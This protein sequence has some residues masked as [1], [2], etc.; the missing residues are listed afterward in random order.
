MFI[1]AFLIL[2]CLTGYIAASHKLLKLPIQFSPFFS[3]STISLTLYLC[4]LTG[5]LQHGT[6]IV[7]IFGFLLAGLLSVYS[8]STK[9]L[10]FQQ[11][12]KN[13]LLILFSLSAI[14]LFYAWK[15]KFSVIDDY[16]YWGI[17]GKYIHISNQLPDTSTSIMPRHLG[18]TPGT[19]LF[20]YLFFRVAG[21]YS[22]ELSY[23]AQNTILS[24]ILFVFVRP[25]KL[26]ESAFI[27]CITIILITLQFGSTIVSRNIVM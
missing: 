21:N 5:K 26:K 4:A 25:D 23:F 6:T 17:I 14:G 24:S 12:L 20:Q 10:F 27:L 3:L 7:I 2:L 8:F 22:Q 13:T 16:V 9:P 15:M 18:Y 1:D 11:S 19:A